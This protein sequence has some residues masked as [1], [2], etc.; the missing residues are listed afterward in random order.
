MG[1]WKTAVSVNSTLSLSL[2]PLFFSPSSRTVTRFGQLTP[3][4]LRAHRENE[5]ITDSFIRDYPYC[6]QPEDRGGRGEREGKSTTLPPAFSIYAFF[7]YTSNG[8]GIHDDGYRGLMISVID[9]DAN[10]T[11][12]DIEY[13]CAR[14]F[15]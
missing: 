2:C 9:D 7:V 8:R 14:C 10:I 1:W 11:H 4:L 15:R 6:P 13:F 3:F 12:D 5:T